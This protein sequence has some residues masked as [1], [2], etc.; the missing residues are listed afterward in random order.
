MNAG[1]SIPQRRAYFRVVYPV[2]AR[3]RLTIEMQI[4]EV[5]DISEKG[6]R[7]HIGNKIFPFDEIIKAMVTFHDK[8][9]LVL[10]GKVIRKEEDEVALLLTEAIPYRRIVKEQQFL[11]KN[12]PEYRF[13]SK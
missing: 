1:S 5:L 10:E 3:P 4:Y 2:S 11:I 12:Y 8:E 9:N 13:N 7:F 6:V